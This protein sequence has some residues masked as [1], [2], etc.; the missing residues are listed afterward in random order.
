MKHCPRSYKFA[1]PLLQHFPIMSAYPSYFD[2]ALKA[3]PSSLDRNNDL[4]ADPS[5]FGKAL[6]GLS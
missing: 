3:Y 4:K 5:Y 1:L 2:E 6:K